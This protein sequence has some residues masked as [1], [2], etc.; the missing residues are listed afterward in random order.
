MLRTCFMVVTS[1]PF[2]LYKHSVPVTGERHTHISN[3]PDVT[4]YCVLS[5]PALLFTKQNF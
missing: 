2:N 5:G 3:K 1:L 4:E